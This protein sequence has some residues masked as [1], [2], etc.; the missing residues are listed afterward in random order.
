MFTLHGVLGVGQKVILIIKFPTL[1][2]VLILYFCT[3]VIYLF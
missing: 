2:N 1:I 3:D